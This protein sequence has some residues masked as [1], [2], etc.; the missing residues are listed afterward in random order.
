ML[1]VLMIATITVLAP[2]D[3]K[4]GHVQGMCFDGIGFY[5]TQM[6]GI[7]K[8]DGLGRPIRSVKAISHYPGEEGAPD[9]VAY[10]KDLKPVRSFNAKA[11]N[12]LEFVGIRDGE[13]RFLKCETVKEGGRISARIVPAELKPFVVVN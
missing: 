13:P 9:L 2:F 6:T 1:Q 3:H 12:G 4:G 7:F 8:V 11:S 10:D 5:L